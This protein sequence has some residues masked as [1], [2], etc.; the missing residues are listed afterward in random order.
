M[1]LANQQAGGD[2][3]K[4][5]QKEQQKIID[6]ISAAQADAQ[7]MESQQEAAPLASPTVTQKTPVSLPENTVAPTKKV[8]ATIKKVELP[9]LSLEAQPQADLSTMLSAPAMAE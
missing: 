2:L 5:D 8:D 9:K 6:Q 1:E 7:A 4:L 3:S